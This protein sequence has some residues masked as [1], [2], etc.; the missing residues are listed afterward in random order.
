[1]TQ[2]MLDLKARANVNMIH[3]Q[4]KYACYRWYII[5]AHNVLLSDVATRSI[6]PCYEIEI[7]DRFEDLSDDI[8]NGD[9]IVHDG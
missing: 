1:M 4:R 2:L 9:D 5:L 6:C 3:F 7:N 8:M